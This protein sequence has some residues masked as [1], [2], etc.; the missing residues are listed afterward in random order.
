MKRYTLCMAIVS[1]AGCGVG[2]T[3][4][5][6]VDPFEPVVSDSS[7]DAAAPSTLA[8]RA[9]SPFTFVD[10]VVSP[11]SFVEPN[12]GADIVLNLLLDTLLVGLLDPVGPQLD[13]S[14]THLERL[15]LDGDDPDFYCRQRFGR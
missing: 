10:P 8:T 4:P 3:R 15:C 7:P 13:H 9:T 12:L 6:M 2:S 11:P 5:A 1:L 14:L